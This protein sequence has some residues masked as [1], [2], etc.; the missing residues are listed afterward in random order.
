MREEFSLV[1]KKLRRIVTAIDAV[2]DALYNEGAVITSVYRDDPRST[3]YY[4]RA[5]DVR[6]RELSDEECMNIVYLMNL[7]FPYG[8]GAYQTVLYHNAGSGWHFHVQ[9]RA[10]HDEE[11]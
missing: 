11:V 5:V 4:Y 8:K 9:V 2:M 10:E 7:M 6:T 3:H 1:D